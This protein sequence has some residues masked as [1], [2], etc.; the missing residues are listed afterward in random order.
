MPMPTT[1]SVPTET[2]IVPRTILNLAL[3]IDVKEGALLLVAGVES[4][5]EVALGHFRHVV[6]VKKL[7]A[8][9]LFT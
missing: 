8:V 9:A 2:S 6:L 1:R 5:V 4:R 7:A 3:R